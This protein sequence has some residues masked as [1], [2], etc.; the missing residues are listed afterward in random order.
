M[1][2]GKVKTDGR[3]IMNAEYYELTTYWVILVN[4]IVATA[5]I[6]LLKI[7]KASNAVAIAFGVISAIWIGFLHWVFGGENIFARDMSGSLFYLIILGGVG[8]FFAV[9]YSTL[10]D[11]FFN[12]SQEYIQMAQGLRVFV[13]G[14]FLMEATLGVIPDWFG[15]M[16]GFFHITSAF[17]ALFAAILYVKR[18]THAKPL[19]WLANIVGV[20]DVLVIAT[21]IC[22]WVW[23]DM[24][25]NHNMMYVVFYAAPIVLWLHFVS[26][27]KLLR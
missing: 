25:A 5:S 6:F 12:L 7:G 2:L 14:G 11:Y 24:G 26:V 18:H 8:V 10:R 17:L 20:T 4:I 13:G 22:F 15:I 21:S 1:F 9:F 3:K 27:R 19:L 23:D 16:D